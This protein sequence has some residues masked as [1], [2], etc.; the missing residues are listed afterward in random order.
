MFYERTK[1]I[2]LRFWGKIYKGFTT[3]IFEST[4]SVYIKTS[5]LITISLKKPRLNE[6]SGIRIPDVL[7]RIM[8]VEFTFCVCR[9]SYGVIK[10]EICINTFFS[11]LLDRLEQ[12]K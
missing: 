2:Y 5:Y 8:S 1:N 4:T 12:E 9:N 3:D 6:F 7:I 11:S 10:T